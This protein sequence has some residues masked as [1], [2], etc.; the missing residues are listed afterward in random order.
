[1]TIRGIDVSEHNGIV[2]WQRIK[3]SGIQ[4]AVIRSSWG[5]FVEDTML[6]RNVS[7]CDRVVMP[8]CLYLYSFPS[9]MLIPFLPMIFPR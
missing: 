7:E 1:M 8:Y 4:F 2:D 3:D 9:K 6:R 5:H